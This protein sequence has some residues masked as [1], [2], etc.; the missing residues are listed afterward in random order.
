MMFPSRTRKRVHSARFLPDNRSR[1]EEDL[2]N[3]GRLAA[4]AVAAWIAD[5]LYGFIVYGNLMTAEFG[6]YPGVFRPLEAMN[7]K[8]P[9]LFAGLLISMFVAAFIYAKGYEGGAGFPEGARF[10]VLIGLFMAGVALGNYAILNI[11]T[12]LAASFAVAGL[13]EW[14]IVGI[15]IGLVYRPAPPAARRAAGV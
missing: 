14:T 15:V 12:R 11:G 4:A 13:V 10:G 2:V 5:G 9:F 3:Y 8:M 6:L 1:E 7:A